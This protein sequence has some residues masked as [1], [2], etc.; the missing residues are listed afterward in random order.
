MLDRLLHDINHVKEFISIDDYSKYA[1]VR[2]MKDITVYEFKYVKL[3][4]E[5]FYYF[6]YRDNVTGDI[7]SSCSINYDKMR[8]ILNRALDR[9]IVE[10]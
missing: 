2:H 9:M 10:G 1:Y 6:T 7:C 4:N 5:T 8:A 3:N